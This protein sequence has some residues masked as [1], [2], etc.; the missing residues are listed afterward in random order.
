MSPTILPATGTGT[1]HLSAPAADKVRTPGSF[2]RYISSL[3]LA[4]RG[5]N[6]PQRVDIVLPEPLLAQLARPI[7]NI[8][9]VMSL[10]SMIENAKARGCF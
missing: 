3:P 9:D 7:N 8:D 6:G 2:E 1:P 4:S 5:R 10:V